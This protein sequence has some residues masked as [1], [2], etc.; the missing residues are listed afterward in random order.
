MVLLSKQSIRYLRGQSSLDRMPWCI[1]LKTHA[2]LMRQLPVRSPADQNQQSFTLS[3]SLDAQFYGL[4]SAAPYAGATHPYCG[5]GVPKTI[6]DCV[7]DYYFFEQ[8]YTL[9]S[10][11][12]A[13]M[14]EKLTLWQQED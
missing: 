7:F 8:K 4:N 12:L 14:L 11:F 5:A 13:Y 1:G 10:I 3:V 9:S 6:H 2:L